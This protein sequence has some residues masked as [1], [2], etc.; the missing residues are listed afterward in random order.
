[1][2]LVGRILGDLAQHA[3]HDLAAAGLGQCRRPLD[4][5]GRGGRADLVA[6]LLHQLPAQRFARLDAFVQGDVGV[7]ALSLDVVREAHDRGLGDAVVADQRALDLGGADAVAADVDHVVHAPGDP[8]VAVG[9]AARAVAGEVHAGIGLEI[10]VD[11]ALRIAV[12]AAH[13]PGPRVQQYQVALGLAF[14]E[15]AVGVDQGRAHAEERDHRGARLEV[16]G[17]DRARQR[18]DE[19]AAG[20]GLPPGVDD[21]A[22]RI[23]DH[24]VV[25]APGFRIDRFADAAQQ[26]Q[27]TARA[28]AHPVVA[29]AHQRADRR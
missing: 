8:P 14:Q 4:V 19:D 28:L 25:P 3:A 24:V 16:F 20:L 7:D 5:V 9:V 17:R 13:L 10:G 26:A 23:A 22:A 12:D 29:F 27:R 15:P 21:R 18:R 6:H 1:A 11:E 2:Q